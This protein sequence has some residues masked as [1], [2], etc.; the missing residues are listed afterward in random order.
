[1]I[2]EQLSKIMLK[3]NLLQMSAFAESGRSKALKQLQL[4]MAIEPE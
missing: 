4:H 1:M 2:A 3:L